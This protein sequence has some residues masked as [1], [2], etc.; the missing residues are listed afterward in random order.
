[1]LQ[2]L[3][4]YEKNM[5]DFSLNSN[6]NVIDKG[7]KQSEKIAFCRGNGRTLGWK[8]RLIITLIT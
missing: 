7:E 3:K 2:N 4:K 6:Y 5:F 8:H 1:M